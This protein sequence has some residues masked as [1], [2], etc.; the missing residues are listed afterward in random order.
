MGGMPVPREKVEKILDA[1]ISIFWRGDLIKEKGT[2]ALQRVRTRGEG[3]NMF[4]AEIRPSGKN[5][6]HRR[7]QSESFKNRR[8]GVTKGGG[9]VV[10]KKLTGD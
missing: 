5:K 6:G 7:F 9:K 2:S 4:R 1:P 3:K 8:R 10:H